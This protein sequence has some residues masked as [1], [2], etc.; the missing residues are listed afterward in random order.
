MQS[1]INKN[2][3]KNF[4]KTTNLN[5]YFRSEYFSMSFNQEKII[6]IKLETRQAIFLTYINE[7]Y[8]SKKNEYL[9]ILFFVQI[10]SKNMKIW[11]QRYT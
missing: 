3:I 11:H 2:I 4:I 6:S 9:K 7:L 5:N 10:D 1:F 8:S